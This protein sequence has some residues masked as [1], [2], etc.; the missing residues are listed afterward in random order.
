M[1][2]IKCPECSR[3]VSSLASCCVHC[4]CPLT[5]EKINSQQAQA[6]DTTDHNK[7]NENLDT[8]KQ[9]DK[10]DL[11]GIFTKL[12]GGIQALLKK[13]TESKLYV[14]AKNW[15]CKIW[16]KLCE[17][18]NRG[19]AS[20]YSLL[21][22]KKSSIIKGAVICI[23]VV[24][25]MITFIIVLFSTCVIMHRYV[26]ATCTEAQICKRC[27]ETKGVQLGHEYVVKSKK[28]ET[29]TNNGLITYVCERCKIKDYEYIKPHPHTASV[30]TCVEPSVCQECNTELK[31]ALGHELVDGTVVVAA[32]CTSEGSIRGVCS[33]CGEEVTD[34]IPITD[35]K[36]G[37]W[38]TEISVTSYSMSAEKK[39]YCTGCELELESEDH[40]LSREEKGKYL[41]SKC[42]SYSYED[43]MRYPDKYDGKMVKF[44]GEVVQVMPSGLNTILRVN[45]TKDRYYWDDTIY[46]WYEGKT[47]DGANICE[48][49]II[50][51]YGMMGGTK[52]YETVLGS[53][54]TIPYLDCFYIEFA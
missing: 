42:K 36:P 27:G 7:T 43:L 4:G 18:I 22:E 39:R 26:D 32:T 54:I 12:K 49:D 20:Y 30:A 21:A 29:C 3:E 11:K 46:V 13:V 9:R 14:G 5:E 2:L 23:P 52:T 15:I 31:P 1:A 35:H 50:W 53:E 47:V 44:K 8:T 6:S 19:K 24:L 34:T 37:E 45:V 48:D 51:L 10:I 17:L 41:K 40:D 33:V 25:V 28:E 38:K 16:D